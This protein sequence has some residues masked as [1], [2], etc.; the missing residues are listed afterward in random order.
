[1]LTYPFLEDK[2]KILKKIAFKRM[3]RERKRRVVEKL[4]EFFKD[5]NTKQFYRE[6][7]SNQKLY[8]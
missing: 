7:G 2:I 6:L 5:N 8:L 4:Q 3:W 1:M